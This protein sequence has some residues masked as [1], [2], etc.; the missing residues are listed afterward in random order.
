MIGE[1]FPPNDFSLFGLSLTDPTDFVYDIIMALLSLYFAYKIRPL[2]RDNKFSLAWYRFFFIFG[3]AAAIGAF[4]HLFY[5]YYHYYGKV[6]GWILVPLAIF[7]IET[8]M[9][10]AHWNQNVI[11]RAR[12]LYK[13]KLL[14][15]YLV[16]MVVWVSV[17]VF[18]KPAL[19]FLPIA[20]NSILGLI[21]GVGVFS[22]QF[23]KKVSTSFATIF[24]GIAVIFPSAFIFLFKINL[25]QWFSKNDFSH[26][27]MIA[28]IIFFY[29][30][31]KKILREDHGF[32]NPN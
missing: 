26:I 1:E 2:K 6:V 25:H 13:M 22:Y 18:A 29:V 12:R 5:H 8:A 30:G 15:V 11:K 20:I 17:D 10:E 9:I 27:L 23:R 32:L 3:I 4:G 16:F 31:V 19:L 21:I 24:F 28:G 7:W 14:L